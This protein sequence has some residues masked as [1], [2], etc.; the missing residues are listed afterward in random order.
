M[1]TIKF[2]KLI[3]FAACLLLVSCME[4]D[5]YA[6]FSVSSSVIETGQTVSFTNKST[7]ADHFEWFFG[8]GS[9]STETNPSHSYS[10]MGAYLVTLVAYSKSG[11]KMD[12]AYYAFILVVDPTELTFQVYMD[13]S[14][15]N[16][17]MVVLFDSYSD[18]YNDVNSVATGYTNSSGRITFTG[19]SDIVY[20]ADFYYN[21]TYYTTGVTEELT[22]FEENIYNV[23]LSNKQVI[24]NNTTHT[25]ISID[26]VGFANRTIPAGESTTYQVS[27]TSISYS[28]STSEVYS[29]GDPLALTLNWNN[30]IT[31]ST[32]VTTRNLVIGSDYSFV[33]F[34]NN[35]GTNLGPIYTNYGNS[36][37]LVTVNASIPSDNVNYRLGYHHAR[38]DTEVRAYYYSGSYYCYWYQG[39]HFSFPFTDNQEVNLW[40]EGKSSQ[41]VKV[42]NENM[43]LNSVELL[44][45][46]PYEKIRP[47]YKKDI[48]A[49]EELPTGFSYN[50]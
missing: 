45:L 22:L 19:C 25:P 6:D 43:P 11:N 24:F 3:L 31:L 14:P 50:K 8:D 37:Y 40:M 27:G 2:I 9:S 13:S 28:A 5:P 26:V 16:N 4:E 7:D 29:N 33:Y 18:W 21:S 38:Y 42:D 36:T 15:L 30:T 47:M 20:Y 34:R 10:E 44:P 46:K 35:F 12:D 32:D 49:V 39:V 17:C 41:N 48:K 1:K 23:Y